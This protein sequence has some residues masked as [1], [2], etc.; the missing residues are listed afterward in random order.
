MDGCEILRHWLRKPNGINH[1]STGAFAA[2]VGVFFW[3]LIRMIRD[4]MGTQWDI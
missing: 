3:D 1:L 4:D 2:T